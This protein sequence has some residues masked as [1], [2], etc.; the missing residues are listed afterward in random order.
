ME[1]ATTGRSGGGNA[2]FD[3]EGSALGDEA[4]VQEISFVLII[5]T[6]H[7]ARPVFLPVQKVVNLAA[8]A[9]AVVNQPTGASLVPDPDVEPGVIGSTHCQ[10]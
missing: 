4:V 1:A 3:F 2:G 5:A 9:H 8:M 7:G 10:S 6:Q